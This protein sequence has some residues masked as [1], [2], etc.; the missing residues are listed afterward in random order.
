MQKLKNTN[1]RYELFMEPELK[2]VASIESELIKQARRYFEKNGFMEVITP[3][4]TKATGSCENV[5]TVFGVS[6]VVCFN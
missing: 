2:A 3:H 4:I 5:M 6:T 1:N